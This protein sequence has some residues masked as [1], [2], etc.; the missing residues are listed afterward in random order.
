M[1]LD[2]DPERASV[3][4]V[5]V[6]AMLLA[7]GVILEIL[8][9]GQNAMEAIMAMIGLLIVTYAIGAIFFVFRTRTSP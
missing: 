2:I 4:I 3:S 8:S 7:T 6:I 9:I 5:A 1:D